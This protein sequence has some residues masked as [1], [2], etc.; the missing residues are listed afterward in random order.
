[1]KILNGGGLDASFGGGQRAATASA[2]PSGDHATPTH[3]R[4][5]AEGHTRV[6]PVPSRR[7]I[8]RTPRES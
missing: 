8:Q 3:Q 6:R 2:F 1:M 7:T 5:D 4:R